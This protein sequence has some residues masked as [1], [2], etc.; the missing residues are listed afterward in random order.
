[1]ARQEAYRCLALSAHHLPGQQGHGYFGA[2][3]VAGGNT[4][5]PHTWG[6]SIKAAF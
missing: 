1:M 2:L 4:G 6:A 5:D 3:N